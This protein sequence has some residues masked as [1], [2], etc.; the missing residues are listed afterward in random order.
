MKTR[1]SV[2]QNEYKTMDTEALREHFLLDD[3]F[4]AGELTLTYCEIERA[5]V[6]AAV[7]TSQVLSLGVTK[8]LASNYFCERREL[9]VLN[10]GGKGTIIVDGTQF[11][12]DSRD[13][14]YVGRGSEAISFESR[15][16]ENP[17]KFYLVSYPAHTAYPTTLATFKE[18]NAVELGSK[19]TSNERIIYQYIHENGI[20][21]CQLVMGFT[22]LSEGCVWNTMPAHT[23]ER[24]TEVYM[25]FD[26]AADACVFHL[27]GPG[28]QTRHIVTQNEQAVV[29]PMWSIHSGCGTQAYTFCW[30]MGGENQRFD[31]MDHIAVPDLR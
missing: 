28:D 26:V 22:Q 12:L 6:G 4:V 3:L 31:D 5:I 13:C 11:E 9:G 1:Y 23:H 2:S 21:S 17:A 25:Y 29:S 16:V 20:K 15:D 7:P 10:V 24:R 14:L 18:A 27:M 8:A 19:A 30:A